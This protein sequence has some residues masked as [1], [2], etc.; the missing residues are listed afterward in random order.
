MQAELLPTIPLA[1]HRLLQRSPTMAHRRPRT[2]LQLQIF[3]RLF[4]LQETSTQLQIQ[5]QSA[6][7]WPRTIPSPIALR[8]FL[9]PTTILLK[10]RVVACLGG[11]KMSIDYDLSKK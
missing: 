2:T 8:W 11:K 9:V 5:M 6:H 7:F 4:R 3:Q 10:T 1:T